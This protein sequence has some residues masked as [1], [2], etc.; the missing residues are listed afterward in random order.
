MLDVEKG[1]IV[2]NDE[3]K[4]YEQLN[5]LCTVFRDKGKFN[6]LWN[7]RNVKYQWINVI[8]DLEQKIMN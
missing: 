4:I 8:R 3:E 2:L 6:A 7:Q 1:P 5:H